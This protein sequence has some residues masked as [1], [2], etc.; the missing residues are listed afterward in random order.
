MA[1]HSA[2]HVLGL[3]LEAH[4]GA[5]ALLCD[6]PAL[7]EGGFFYELFLRSGRTVSPDDLPALSKIAT[8]AIKARHQFRRLVLSRAQ[9]QELFSHNPFKLH[10]L[11]RIPVN[12]VITAYRCG[13]F[14]DLCRGPHLPLTATCGALGLTRCAGSQGQLTTHLAHSLL[15][16]DLRPATVADSVNVALQRVYGVA[17]PTAD[18]LQEWERKQEEARRRDHRVVGR[19]QKL[20]MFHDASPGSCFFLPHGQRILN[21]LYDFMRDEYWKRGYQEVSTPLLY[22]PELW[23]TSGHLANYG[24]NMFA[25]TPGMT[26]GGRPASHALF[27]E[28]ETNVASTSDAASDGGG[29]CA[30]HQ[31]ASAAAEPQPGGW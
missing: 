1:W 12:T 10:M 24:E 15:G 22:R 23:R 2:A 5:D 30:H 18:Q 14:V 6:G 13:A 27:A 29:C 26:A 25:V 17:F 11:D 4:Y 16:S 20:F 28:Q 3:A 31:H 8:R 9:A 21:R 7:D 19:A